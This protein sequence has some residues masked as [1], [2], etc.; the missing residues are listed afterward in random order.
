M[1]LMVLCRRCHLEDSVRELVLGRHRPE[2]VTLMEVVMLAE[3]REL[4]LRS[5]DIDA[6][7]PNAKQGPY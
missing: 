4:G 7:A 5:G 6:L 1:L 2:D 3:K